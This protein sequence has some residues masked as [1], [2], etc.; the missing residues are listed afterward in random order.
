MTCII[1][2]CPYIGCSNKLAL[3]VKDLVED[4]E[5]KRKISQSQNDNS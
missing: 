3:N 2:R 5:L 4:R 1:C